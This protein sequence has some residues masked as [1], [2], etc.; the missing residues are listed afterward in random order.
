MSDSADKPEGA[1]NPSSPPAAAAASA[2]GPGPG[3]SAGESFGQYLLRE[4]ELRG[5]SLQQVSDT[6]RI[7]VGNLKALEADDL[8][9]LPA[10]VFVLGYIRVYA[11][12]IGL[13]ADEAVLRYEEQSQKGSPAP[14]ENEARRSRKGRV[15]A[16]VLVAALAAGGAAA[17][18]LTR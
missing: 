12:A 10:R 14:E 15:L 4:R 6:T 7:G 3:P 5:F 2:P 1:K 17:F 8:S 13:S 9:R 16:A 18:L 11:H